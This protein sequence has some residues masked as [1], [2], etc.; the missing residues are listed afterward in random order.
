MGERSGFLLALVL[1]ERL[2]REA[3]RRVEWAEQPSF[4]LSPVCFSLEK[5]FSVREET[6]YA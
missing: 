5:P 1:G 6:G 3:L 2:S 4:Q